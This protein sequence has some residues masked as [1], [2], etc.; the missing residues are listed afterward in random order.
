MKKITVDSFKDFIQKFV[1]HDIDLVDDL[2]ESIKIGIAKNR[3]KINIFSIYC[4]ETDS[5]YKISVNREECIPALKGCLNT[6]IKNEMYEKC[7]EVKSLLEQLN[8]K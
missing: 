2:F 4:R 8:N 6:F 7:S 3:K 5:T 1:D